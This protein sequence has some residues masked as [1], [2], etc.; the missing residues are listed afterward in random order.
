MKTEKI[1]IE[2]ESPSAYGTRVWID[3]VEQ[4]GLTSIEFKHASGQ[5]AQLRLDRYSQSS[6]PPLLQ[7]ITAGCRFFIRE[8]KR[9]L[10]A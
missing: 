4:R 3:G 1:R 10:T 2:A 7:R 6:K 8:M 9:A 5:L